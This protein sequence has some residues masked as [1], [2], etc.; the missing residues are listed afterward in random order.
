VQAKL[1]IIVASIGKENNAGLPDV[2]TL[3][4]PEGKAWIEF[5]C[6]CHPVWNNKDL[7]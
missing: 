2:F 1:K 3:D 6:P 7:K 5:P 4:L